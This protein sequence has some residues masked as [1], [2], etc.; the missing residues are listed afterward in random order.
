MPAALQ[1]EQGPPKLPKSRS[2]RVLQGNLSRS[3]RASQLPQGC[4]QVVQK[5]PGACS[6]IRPSATDAGPA[7]AQ[8]GRFRKNIGR[9]LPLLPKFV[10][11]S[12]LS[13]SRCLG[14]NSTE[15]AKSAEHWKHLVNIG[16]L[17]TGAGWSWPNLATI[18]RTMHNIDQISPTLAKYLVAEQ[19]LGNMC[20]TCWHFRG[21]CEAVRDRRGLHSR[22]RGD[23]LFDN[24]RGAIFFLAESASPRTPASQVLS[25]IACRP[26]RRRLVGRGVNDFRIRAETTEEYLA[27]TTL[28]SGD[29]DDFK[30][31]I[32]GRA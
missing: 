29:A 6:G 3:R 19:R 27:L 23:Q 21:N 24:I 10:K 30:Q 7:S 25:S 15:L 14:A 16:E 17:W 11:L 5:L 9:R 32:L 2:A 22:K 28:T 1:R 12:G 26:S 18:G 4:E 8:F 13:C 20:T 31:R